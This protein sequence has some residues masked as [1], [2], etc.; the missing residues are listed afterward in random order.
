MFVLV[1]TALACADPMA[2]G[3]VPNDGLP[4][5]KAFQAAI[6]SAMAGSHEVCI[7]SGVWN[8]GKT[9]R[10]SLRISGGPL[11]FYGTGPST[12][13]RM[14]GDGGRG[15]WYGI[16]IR[17]AHDV[18][19]RD[20][21]MDAL[22]AFNTEEQTHLIQLAPGTHDARLTNLVLGP[23]RRED[24]GVGAGVGG[25]CVRLLGEASAPVERITITQS[26]FTNCDRSGVS[27]QRGVRHVELS[28]LD[29]VGTGDTP[30]DFEPTAP[31]PIS[32]IT[33]TDLFIDRS[34]DAQGSVSIAIAGHGADVANHIVVK[35]CILQAGGI[36]IL[37][38]AH[39]DIVDNDINS[40][41]KPGATIRMHR[42]ATNVTVT[43]NVLNRRE[44]APAGP[45]VSITHNNGFAPKGVRIVDNQMR[46][47]TS[48]PMVEL[49]S[50]TDVE[51]GNNQ[52]QYA[53]G[54]ATQ[55]MVWARSVIAAVGG[56]KIRR[57]TVRG[58]VGALLVVA[59]GQQP[60]GKIELSNNAADD[61][62][63]TVQCQAND[64]ARQAQIVIVNNQVGPARNLCVLP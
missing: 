4:D 3:A 15:D 39:V 33:M 2:F 60:L 40:G 34:A 61:V 56:L 58:Q 36:S 25:D 46:Q 31:G 63:A 50:A 6:D 48:A 59:A 64:K 41:E 54:D 17:D 38:A 28:H 20:F 52:M 7:P 8:L 11:R 45:M 26:L 32:Y 43:R 1:A 22:A 55:P 27:L 23:M 37:N 5:D 57:N 42:R 12:V 14:T 49:Q 10:A 29:I 21:T 16:D 13:L 53:G 9:A 47:E 44:N 18:E 62:A 19:L 35:N 30:I 24:Q 51:V